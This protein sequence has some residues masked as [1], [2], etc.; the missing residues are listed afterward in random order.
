MAVHGPNTTKE[1]RNK[2]EKKKKRKEKEKKTEHRLE[3]ARRP[4]SGLVVSVTEGTYG[5]G[6][7]IS[8]LSGPVYPAVTCD[9]E[10]VAYPSSGSTGSL[11]FCLFF[12][13][14]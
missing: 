6:R 3:I 8:R 14:G 4:Y 5:N 11:C 7:S 2:R 13:A 12:F 10:F 1:T 9:H